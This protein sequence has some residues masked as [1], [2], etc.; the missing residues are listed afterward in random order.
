LKKGKKDN[1]KIAYHQKKQDAEKYRGSEGGLNLGK[2]EREEK[3][4]P[5]EFLM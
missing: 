3:P 5:P 2:K 4:C 1:Q